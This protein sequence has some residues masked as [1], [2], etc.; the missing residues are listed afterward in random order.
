MSAVKTATFSWKKTTNWSVSG[1]NPICIKCPPFITFVYT[2]VK[3]MYYALL[4]SPNNP[5]KA[6]QFLLQ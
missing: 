2:I 4:S 1:Y 3:Y 6:G 5:T